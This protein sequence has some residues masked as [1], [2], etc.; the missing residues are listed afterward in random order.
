LRFGAAAD[1][2]VRPIDGEY[3]CNACHGYLTVKRKAPNAYQVHWVVGDGSCGGVEIFDG[4]TR[5]SRDVLE[6]RY[7]G[8]KKQCVVRFAFNETGLSASDSC[9]S[10]EDEDGSTCA[11]TGAYSKRKK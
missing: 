1:A 10:P 5:F 9:V 7:K 8:S 4:P 2:P 6:G 3:L 11:V